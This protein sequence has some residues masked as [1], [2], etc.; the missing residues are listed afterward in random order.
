LLLDQPINKKYPIA[1][2]LQKR[3][4]KYRGHV[5]TFLYYHHVPP[6]NNGSGR[7]IRNVK[8][9]HKVSGFFKSFDGAH[10]FAVLCSII[11]TS[12][13]NNVNPLLAL[14]EINALSF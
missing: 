12:I 10:S 2:S 13:K 8:I 3:L 4:I 9:K 7:A 5:F 11:D 1:L 14:S 6:D